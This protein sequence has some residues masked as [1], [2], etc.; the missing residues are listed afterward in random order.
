[1]PRLP[2]SLRPSRYVPKAGDYY[3]ES[4]GPSAGLL[5]TQFPVKVYADSPPEK[6]QAALQEALAEWNNVIPLRQ[7]PTRQEAH[8]MMSWTRLQGGRAGTERSFTVVGK[9]GNRVFQR[10]D[11]ASIVLD[12]SHHWSGTQ[13]RFTLLHELGHALGINGHSNGPRT[14]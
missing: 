7:V 9:E 12:N 6:W 3:Q 10:L 5:W 13:I 2:D 11:T 4:A 1:M 14:S 8:I